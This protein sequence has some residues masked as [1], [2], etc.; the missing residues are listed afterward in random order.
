MEE[1]ALAKLG[2]IVYF[3]HGGSACPMATTTHTLSALHIDGFHALS[4]AFCACESS[5]PPHLQLFDNKLFSASI[6]SPKTVF[7]FELLRQFRIHHLESK[8]SAYSYIHSLYRL[9]NDEGSPQIP[10]RIPRPS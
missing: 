6:D 10:V 1:A 2:L 3:G 7:T 5:P 8:E 9:T 4:I